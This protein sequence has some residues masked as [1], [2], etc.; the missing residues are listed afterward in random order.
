MIQSF[1][2]F[3]KSF[4]SY[5]FS[6][7]SVND[8]FAFSVANPTDASDNQAG[9]LFLQDQDFLL[10]ETEI[11]STRRAGPSTS[12]PRRARGTLTIGV[13]TKGLDNEIASLGRLEEVA[14]WFGDSTVGE[15]RY[16]EF[17]PT[18]PSPLRGFTSYDGAIDFDFDLAPM[19]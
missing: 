18:G 4:R 16:R 8:L 7:V 9:E 5:V 2:E 3:E 13:V 19:R 11:Y 6:R 12:A 17:F 14:E 15:V 10:F 1:V